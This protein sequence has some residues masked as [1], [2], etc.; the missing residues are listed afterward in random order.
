MLKPGLDS[1]SQGRIHVV[2]FASGMED[3]SI[4]VRGR[5]IGNYIDR[6]LSRVGPVSNLNQIPPSNSISTSQ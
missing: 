3:H 5:D 4:S 2:R 6:L 1:A